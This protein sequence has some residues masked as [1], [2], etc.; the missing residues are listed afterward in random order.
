MK[1]LRAIMVIG[2][3]AFLAWAP[4]A[5]AARLYTTGFEAASLVAS[6]DITQDGTFGAPDGISSTQKHG[7]SNSVYFGQT[8][9]AQFSWVQYKFRSAASAATTTARVYVYFNTLFATATELMSLAN[10]GPGQLA[11]ARLN[12]SNQV[13]LFNVTPVQVG[14]CSTALTTGGWHSIELSTNG[15]SNIFLRVD[16]VL[17]ASGFGG[18]QTGATSRVYLGAAFFSIAKADTYMDDLA[19]NDGSGSVQT[20]YPG[21]GTVIRL[22]PNAAGD[23]NTFATQ[24]GGTAGAANNFSRVNETTPN[25][26]TSFNGSNTLNQEDFYN[27][28]D[29]GIG[30]SD[31]VTLVETHAWYRGSVAATTAT[32]KPEIKKAAAGTISQGTGV[33]PNATTFKMNANAAPSL[34]GLTL[35]TDPD[36]AAWTQATLDSMQLGMKVTTG[37]TNRDDISTLWVYVEYVPSGIPPVTNTAVQSEFFIE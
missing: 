28:T 18:T 32:Y 12:T 7:G 15:S 8:A 11:S 19:V 23:V 16:G 4:T 27:V 34:P 1:N 17:V 13:C 35:Y 25:D 33:A 29:S 9:T 26:A 24:T 5:H 37:S 2:V 22:T 30:A 10:E 20:W 6:H 36:G 3:V 21:E 14:S 31:T